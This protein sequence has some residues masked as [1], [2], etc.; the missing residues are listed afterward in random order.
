MKWV[1][2]RNFTRRQWHIMMLFLSSITGWMVIAPIVIVTS[3]LWDSYDTTTIFVLIIVSMI[4]SNGIMQPLSKKGYRYAQYYAKIIVP[5]ET[6]GLGYA[7]Y[8]T[9]IFDELF[10]HLD[11]SMTRK[12]GK[13]YD[14]LRYSFANSTCTA[15]ISI[16]AENWDTD[17]GDITIRSIIEKDMPF[18]IELKDLIG[19]ALGVEEPRE[20][21][22]PPPAP[23]PS[24]PVTAND[25]TSLQPSIDGVRSMGFDDVRYGGILYKDSDEFNRRKENWRKQGRIIF[26]VISACFVVGSF[27]MLMNDFK[28]S[29]VLLLFGALF[30]II[31]YLASIDPGHTFIIYES[32]IR[33][34]YAKIPFLSFSDVD[35][36]EMRKGSKIESITP[37]PFPHVRPQPPLKGQITHLSHLQPLHS[38]P[39][40]PPASHSHTFTFP[41]TPH[42]TP[43]PVPPF[44][45]TLPSYF[46]SPP[47]PHFLSFFPTPPLLGKSVPGSLIPIPHND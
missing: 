26:T 13:Y 24:A 30:F 2:G 25:N 34:S 19:M 38:G 4:V 3:E 37:S 23:P 32:G 12:N 14:M 6:D 29:C 21:A 27:M 28:S 15:D 22:P 41:P 1:E 43:P 16:P 45:F 5:D 44:S 7:E 8:Y 36:L 40:P 33:F 31:G 11:T 35:H 20:I 9:K 47:S 39:H 42:L 17:L 10:T 46:L 18:L